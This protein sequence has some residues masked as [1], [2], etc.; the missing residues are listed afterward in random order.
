MAA[1]IRFSSRLI[2]ARDRRTS[3]P[4]GCRHCG[5]H[6]SLRASRLSLRGCFPTRAGART[7]DRTL[8][9]ALAVQASLSVVFIMNRM[10]IRALIAI[11]ALAGLAI[12]LTAAG[13]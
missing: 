9:P 11:A 8:T 12:V 13:F 3:L 6:G 5:R 4:A 10:G 1:Y 2:L 7:N